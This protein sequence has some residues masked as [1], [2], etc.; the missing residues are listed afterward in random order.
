MQVVEG[1][2]Y[3]GGLIRSGPMSAVIAG[4]QKMPDRDHNIASHS[5]SGETLNLS[6]DSILVY[7]RLGARNLLPVTRAGEYSQAGTKSSIKLW[8]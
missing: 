2:W 1:W 7:G 5:S 3:N 8:K 6:P 4:D